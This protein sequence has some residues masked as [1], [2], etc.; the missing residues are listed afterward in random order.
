MYAYMYLYAQRSCV[1]DGNAVGLLFF[2]FFSF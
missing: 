2:F 1:D